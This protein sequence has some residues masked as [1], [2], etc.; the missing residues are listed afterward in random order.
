AGVTGRRLSVG[1]GAGVGL[2]HGTAD[3]GRVAGATRVAGIPGLGRAVDLLGALNSRGRADIAAKRAA[4]LAGAR[5]VRNCRGLDPQ[6]DLGAGVPGATRLAGVAGLGRRAADA[7]GAGAAG[8]AGV[9][10]RGLSI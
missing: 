2:A 5:V 1:P 3:S 8:V 9:G 7:S 6:G 10:S 4:E